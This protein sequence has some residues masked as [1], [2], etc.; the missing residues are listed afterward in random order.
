MEL[1]HLIL[2]GMVFGMKTVTISKTSITK[3]T[4]KLEFH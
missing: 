4:K 1:H 3:Y 2:F